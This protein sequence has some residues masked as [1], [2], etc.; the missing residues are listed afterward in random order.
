MSWTQTVA[1]TEAEFRRGYWSAVAGATTESL[2][3]EQRMLST[4]LASECEAYRSTN[5]RN[6][7]VV[8]T[9]L[10]TRYHWMQDEANVVVDNSPLYVKY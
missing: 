5:L 3:A 1:R 9:E 6:L 10:H 8:N 7:R 4:S 2:F